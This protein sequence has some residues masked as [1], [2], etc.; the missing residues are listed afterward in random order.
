MGQKTLKV[1]SYEDEGVRTSFSFDA[2]LDTE[3]LARQIT[4][5]LMHM[6]K[7]A[8]EMNQYLQTLRDKQDAER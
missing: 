7:A 6:E 4:I 5:T 1:F 3:T 8:G 2:E